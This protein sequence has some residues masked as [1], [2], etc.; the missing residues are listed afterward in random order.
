MGERKAQHWSALSRGSNHQ[1]VLLLLRVLLYASAEY[2][3]EQQNSGEVFRD[4]TELEESHVA[5]RIRVYMLH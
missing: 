1:R 2:E 5:V 4:L 3:K